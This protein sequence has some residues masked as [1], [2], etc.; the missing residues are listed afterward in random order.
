ME[1]IKNY[2]QKMP[3][4]RFIGIQ[5]GD[6]DRENNTFYL[7]W[8]EW[9][10][11]GYFSLIKNNIDKDVVFDLPEKDD[12]IG[13]MR[14][15]EG[16]PFQYWIGLF[17]PEETEVPEGFGYLDFIETEIG[18]SWVYGS[19]GDVFG[20]EDKCA[21]ALLKEGYH[22][23]LESDKSIW[24]FERYDGERY[25]KPDDKGNIILDICYFLRK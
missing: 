1:I 13:L 21:E 6:E 23:K 10:D 3:K 2:S 16:E 25:A 12:Y 17:T 7:K 20:V 19:G 22:V 5:Y 8:R 4:S 15:K 24:F 14:F 9:L 11:N 18:V